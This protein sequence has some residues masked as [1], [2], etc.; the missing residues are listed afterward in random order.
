MKILC[1]IERL[2]S[3][4]GAERQLLTLARTLTARG[5]ECT[6]AALFPGSN[7]ASELPAL[8]IGFHE[9]KIPFQRDYIRAA[10][11]LARLVRRGKFDVVQAHLLP[12][13]IASG[14]SRTLASGPARVVV[15]HNLDYE[16]Y[17]ARTGRQKALRSLHALCLRR[18]TDGLVAVSECV[19]RHYR[20]E[21]GLG[22]ITAI[23]NSIELDAPPQ[24]FLD[25]R[26]AFRE[27]LGIAN[28]TSL[29]V[30]SA[31]MVKQKGHLRLFRVLD[32]LRTRGVIPKVMLIG[33]GPLEAEIRAAVE[34][35]GIGNQV[36]MT[37]NIPHEEAL[38]RIASADLFISPSDQE[39]FPLAPAEAM[40]LGVPVVATAVGGVP[41]L[42]ED[43]VTGLLVPPGNPEAL[44]DAVARALSD[45]GMRQRFQSAAPERIQTHFTPA[46][47]ARRWE[48]YFK[49]MIASRACAEPN[50]CRV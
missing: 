26:E 28:G 31:R 10:T 32:I 30:Y 47:I 39:G 27:E 19:A 44:A 23:P 25:K 38:K 36:I 46:V 45:R 49:E 43:G 33:S 21:M 14:L 22:H 9:L 50:E 6:I 48:A 12:A 24:V 17:P 13:A 29:L 42:V 7:L 16:I 37:G 34:S 8:G 5:H 2:C 41:E 4:G 3:P 40:A 18:F 35:G 20:N 15:L 11:R 1:V